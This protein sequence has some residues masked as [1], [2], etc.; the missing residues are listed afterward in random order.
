MEKLTLLVPVFPLISVLVALFIKQDKAIG[1]VSTYLTA[2]SFFL[3]LGLLLT[4][5]FGEVK[6][7]GFVDILGDRLGLLLS[8][9]VLLVSLVVHRFSVN[10]MNDD[11][12]YR[13]FF[14]LLDL[15]TANLVVLVLSGNLI[16][17][18]VSW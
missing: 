13:R 4:G 10:Y 18:A 16:L 6:W 7:Y 11:P 14:L 3:S 9:Y 15:M 8:T 5:S 2:V 1:R 17:L 12:G